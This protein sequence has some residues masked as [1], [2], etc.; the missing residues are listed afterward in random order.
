MPVVKG[1][2]LL[3][4]SIR[5]IRFGV[6]LPASSYFITAHNNDIRVFYIRE[7]RF[8]YCEFVAY[9]AILITSIP[10]DKIPVYRFQEI[11]K[12]RHIWHGL[13]VNFSLLYGMLLI[14][15]KVQCQ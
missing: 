8:I 1:I 14:V 15:H 10:R 3:T 9:L 5:G 13:Q 12:V 2:K 6:Q 4:D 7:F 11:S